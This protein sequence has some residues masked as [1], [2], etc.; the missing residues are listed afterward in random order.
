MRTTKEIIEDLEA[1]TET[2]RQD[3]ESW[4]RHEEFQRLMDELSEALKK[5]GK[6]TR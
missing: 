1:L 5:Y 2:A 3:D 4:S 6:T